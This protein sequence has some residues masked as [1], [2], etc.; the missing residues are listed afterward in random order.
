M[1]SMTT[2]NIENGCYC[3]RFLLLFLFIE[4]IIELSK[5]KKKGNIEIK[6]LFVIVLVL[7]AAVNFPRTRTPQVT[8][9]FMKRWIAARHVEFEFQIVISIHGNTTVVFSWS[10][11]VTFAVKYNSWTLLCFFFFFVCCDNLKLETISKGI[12]IPDPLG[13]QAYELKLA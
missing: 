4:S 1:F 7:M 13:E 9:G 10:S 8:K 5:K 12:Q 2:S 11:K 3:S 6:H